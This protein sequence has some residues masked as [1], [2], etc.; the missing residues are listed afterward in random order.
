MA[1]PDQAWATPLEDN[2]EIVG[3]ALGVPQRATELQAGLDDMIVSVAQQHPE[4]E[5]VT[6]AYGTVPMDD[7][8]LLLNGPTDPR[9]QLIEQLGMTLAPGVAGLSEDSSSFNVSL[10]DLSDISPQLY[11]TNVDGDAEWERALTN[12]SV[13]GGW[14]PIADGHV[15]VTDDVAQT[16]SLSAPS[17]LSIPWGLY[18]LVGALAEAVENLE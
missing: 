9:V 10:E 2:I 8:T 7:G 12:S 3:E 5:G 1:Y 16:M 17:P 15:V 6:F 11:V 13:F 18:N 4:F 14:R